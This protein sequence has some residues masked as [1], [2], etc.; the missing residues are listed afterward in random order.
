MCFQGIEIELE[1]NN[2]IGLPFVLR[3][4]GNWYK[5]NGSDYYMP[6]RP[7]DKKAVKVFSVDMT[8]QLFITFCF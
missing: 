4:G 8:N 3:S 5:D 6:V 7:A 1:D 2:F